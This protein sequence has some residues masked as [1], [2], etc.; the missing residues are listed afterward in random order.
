MNDHPPPRPEG[1]S[2][3]SF[4]QLLQGWL[5]HLGSRRN[6]GESLRDSLEELIQNHGDEAV[7][8][9]PEE[10]TMFVNLLNFGDLR[11]DDVSKNEIQELSTL[12]Y[13]LKSSQYEDTV[14]KNGNGKQDFVVTVKPAKLDEIKQALHVILR[15]VKA[16]RI[17][18][19]T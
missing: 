2:A 17:A 4:L 6:G 14:V 8:I 5:R 13:A 15:I 16:E 19:D 9:D 12:I 18:I 10:R 7:P 3:G 11:I 1:E